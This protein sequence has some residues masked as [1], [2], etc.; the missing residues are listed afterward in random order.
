[1]GLDIETIKMII[2]RRNTTKQPT[3]R[4]QMK[5]VIS[6]IAQILGEATTIDGIPDDRLIAHPV[7]WGRV[8]VSRDKIPPNQILKIVR[9]QTLIEKLDE[10]GGT[11]SDEELASMVAGDSFKKMED[12]NNFLGNDFLVRQDSYAQS[13][14]LERLII[15]IVRSLVSTECDKFQ[16]GYR[17]NPNSEIMFCKMS[18]GGP[19]ED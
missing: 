6:I 9:L 5:N 11:V 8:I 4:I 18:M 10:N 14:M 2:E 3:K 19:S 7:G 17:V 13:M 15:E 12:F 1:M 16:V